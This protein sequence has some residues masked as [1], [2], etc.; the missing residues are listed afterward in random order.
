MVPTSRCHILL[1]LASPLFSF[2]WVPRACL[3]RDCRERR[4][5]SVLCILDTADSTGLSNSRNIRSRSRI[6]RL[7]ASFAIYRTNST[8]AAC[9][10]TSPNWPQRDWFQTLVIPNEVKE[11]PRST[12]VRRLLW[13]MLQSHRESIPQQPS[14]SQARAVHRRKA[15]SNPGMGDRQGCYVVGQHAYNERILR[16]PEINKA[17]T[18]PQLV[19]SQVYEICTQRITAVPAKPG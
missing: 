7:P 15:G 14:L 10:L 2:E 8:L 16:A 6:R 1:S 19:S 3:S 11:P 12:K 9:P 4:E 17:R 5:I 18:F 13:C